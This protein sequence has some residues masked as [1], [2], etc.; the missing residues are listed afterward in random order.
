MENVTPSPFVAE[1][2]GFAGQI[3]RR[4]SLTWEPACNIFVE[5]VYED[6]ANS[7]TVMLTNPLTP[8]TGTSTHVWFAWSRNFGPADANDPMSLKFEKQSLQVLE[9]DLSLMEMQQANIERAEAFRPA[10]IT[11]DATLV[12]ARRVL[13]RLRKEEAPA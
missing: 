7:I 8:E 2:G 10:I 5:M 3:N 9:E 12:Q 11:A 1:W 13:D 4:A 6:A